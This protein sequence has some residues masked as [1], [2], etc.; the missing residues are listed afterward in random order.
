M[1]KQRNRMNERVAPAQVLPS[2][3][4]VDADNSADRRALAAR[5]K[6]AARLGRLKALGL[7]APLLLFLVVSFILP[8]ALLLV[9]AVDNR[10]IGALLPRT[11]AILAVWDGTDL[12]PDQ[13]FQAF[14]AELAAAPGSATADIARRLNFYRPSIRSM[15]MKTARQAKDIAPEHAREKLLE[16]DKG[17]GE[18]EVWQTLKVASPSFTNYYILR[19]LDLDRG[20]GGS[21]EV[22]S[23]PIYAAVLVR[24]LGISLGVTALCLILGYPLAYLLASV[25]ERTSR[26]LMMFVLL[27]FW[28]SLLVRTT[29]WL[30]LLQGSGVVNSLL[31]WAGL[32]SDPLELIHN[33]IGVFVAMTHILLPFVVLPLHAVM[34][35]IPNVYM[36]AASSLGAPSWRAFLHVYLPLT[37]PGVGAGSLLVFILS[38]GY[39]ITPMLVGGPRDQMLSSFIAYFVNQ[40]TNWSMAAALATIL[41]AIVALLYVVLAMVFGNSRARA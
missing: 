37:L 32:I 33:R 21:L 3:V 13:A 36:R 10:E 1:H 34:K 15:I 9:R 40:S 41:L 2:R 8:I 6:L 35:G 23:E 12:P 22:V 39:Y 26:I 28:T 16:A 5:L 20:P 14:A 25:D 31:Q 11:S 27:P 7:V 24:T 18:P 4:V 30:V 29:A 17:W 38:L 19:A